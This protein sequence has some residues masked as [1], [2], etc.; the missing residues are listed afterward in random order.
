MF[1]G[2][3]DKSSLELCDVVDNDCDI[4]I[5]EDFIILGTFCDS[6]DSDFCINGIF[7]CL[8]NGLGVEC[9]NELIIDIFEICNN[10]DDDCDSVIDE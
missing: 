7:I 8:F 4:V 5:D 3:V 1:G 2:L 10:F 9:V 6:D